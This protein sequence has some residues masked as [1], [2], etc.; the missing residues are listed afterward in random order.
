VSSTPPL[1]QF[2]NAFGASPFGVQM[3]YNGTDCMSPLNGKA[4]I[5]SEQALLD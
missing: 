5:V 3:Y 2:S 1:Q 4:Y